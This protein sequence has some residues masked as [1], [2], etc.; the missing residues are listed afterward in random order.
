MAQPLKQKITVIFQYSQ[1]GHVQKPQL[2][3]SLLTLLLL[4]TRFLVITSKL[5]NNKC[6]C[7]FLEGGAEGLAV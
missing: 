1:L 7:A 3:F 5:A 2:D 6:D 4:K